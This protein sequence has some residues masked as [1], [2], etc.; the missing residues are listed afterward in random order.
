MNQPIIDHAALDA[1]IEALLLLDGEAECRAFLNDLCTPRELDDL[2][3]RLQ[4]AALLKDGRNYQDISK[5]T[6]AS[7]ATISRVKQ[8][9]VRGSGGYETVLNRKIQGE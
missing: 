4:V 5:I 7:T 1:L 8:A 3:Q 2:S 6:G 9:L